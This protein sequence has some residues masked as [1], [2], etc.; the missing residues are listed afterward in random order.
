MAVF[1]SASTV[2]G[3]RS[4]VPCPFCYTEIHPNRAAFRC[5]GRAPAGSTENCVKAK[6]DARDSH[7]GD[8]TPVMP[9]IKKESGEPVLAKFRAVCTTCGAESGVRVCPECHSLLPSGFGRGSPLFGLV[10][11]RNSGKTVLLSVLHHEIQ[12]SV[13]RRFD[14]SIDTPGGSNGL[15]RELERNGQ[16][17]A[18]ARG[19]LPA[20]TQQSGGNKKVPAVYEWKYVRKKR[21]VSTVFSFYDNAGE[22]VSSQER[23]LEQLYLHAA[24]GVIVLLDPFAFPENL[25]NLEGDLKTRYEGMQAAPEDVLDAI[26]QLL[27]SAH[28]RNPN[29][30]IKTPIAVAVSK[31]D[32][33]FDQVPIEHPL[34]APS[35]NQPFFDEEEAQSVHDHLASMIEKWGGDGLLRKLEQNYSTYRLF[36]VSALGA[37]PDYRT[38][39]VNSRGLLPHRVAEPLLWLMATHG[40]I[41][42]EA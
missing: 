22:D 13:A 11:V 24:S 1:S 34:R 15:A 25:A 5:T 7:F 16:V 18:K 33:Y 3:R 29:K 41:P 2:L 38:G 17:M 30:K 9:V 42:K 8:G 21:T 6:D 12:N 36:G 35:S 4:K 37:E 32:A 19:T 26:T 27:R 39:N 28:T 10:G 14:A 31:I 40:F 23:A 20:Q